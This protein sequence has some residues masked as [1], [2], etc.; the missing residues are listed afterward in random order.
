VLLLGGGLRSIT[1]WRRTAQRY[2]LEED[3]A[4]LLLGG[5]LHSVT[6]WRKTA[7]RYSL[8]EDC[9]LCGLTHPHSPT[10][11]STAP[12]RGEKPLQRGR[13]GPV[14]LAVTVTPLS[15]SGTGTR[16]HSTAVRAVHVTGVL[17]EDAC[18]SPFPD[19]LCPDTRGNARAN[20]NLSF[21]SPSSS[22]APRPRE[23]SLELRFVV[24][25][26]H[27]KRAAGPSLRPAPD[28]AEFALVEAANRHPRQHRGVSEGNRS[29]TKRKEREGV[30]TTLPSHP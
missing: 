30:G 1:P 29:A 24:R 13:V 11:P 7:Q 9:T 3:C 5:G 18:V 28:A 25:N 12:P 14:A 15:S 2:S 16:R 19:D 6:L 23:C 20:S 4:A 26:A 17:K 21:R 8:E 10:F 22:Y 27:S